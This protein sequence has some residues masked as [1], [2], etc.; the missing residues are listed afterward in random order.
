MDTLGDMTQLEAPLR[1]DPD[2]ADAEWLPR[3]MGT[4]AVVAI[5]AILVVFLVALSPLTHDIDSGS[6]VRASG[7]VELTEEHP[8]VAVEFEA[9]LMALGDDPTP[10]Y[11]Q[12]YVVTPGSSQDRPGTLQSG[13]FRRELWDGSQWVP[14]DGDPV[15]GRPGINTFRTRWIF[16]LAAG[17]AQAAIPYEIEINPFYRGGGET[18]PDAGRDYEELQIRTVSTYPIE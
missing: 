3:R 16:A 14:Y 5:V 6:G 17:L 2:G 15:I 13:G 8:V 1:P 7:E 4:T 9:S 10:M 12:F 11:A 18:A